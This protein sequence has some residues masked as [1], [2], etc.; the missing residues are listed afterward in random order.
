[1][2]YD[3][4]GNSKNINCQVN[5]VEDIYG[6]ILI[7]DSRFVGMETYLGDD[8]R[9]QDTFVAKGAMGWD[10]FKSTAIAK[11]NNILEKYSNRKYYILCNLGLND[12]KYHLEDAN[13][14]KRLSTLAK[15]E[16]KDHIVG[17]I[18]V[19][20]FAS[21]KDS[22]N[23]MVEDFNARQKGDM[24]GIYYCDTYNGIGLSNFEPR[25]SSDT[26]HYNKNTSLAIY[27]YIINNCAF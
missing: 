17:Y 10:W 9:K 12:Y 20:P 14:A 7:G 16:W 19:N 15:N 23:K 6:F 1:M 21:V 24:D 22:R 11:V 27:D 8:K 3:K 18:S 5:I 25:K 2:V 4:A 13:Y 26:T